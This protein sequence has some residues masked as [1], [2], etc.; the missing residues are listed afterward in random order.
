MINEFHLIVTD[1][2]DEFS[3]DSLASI[4]QHCSDY[5]KHV[6]IYGSDSNNCKEA[7]IELSGKTKYKDKEN[8]KKALYKV[9]D[10]VIDRL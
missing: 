10:Y 9:I 3:M 5:D 6:L 1:G 2:K 4:M 8:L 7:S